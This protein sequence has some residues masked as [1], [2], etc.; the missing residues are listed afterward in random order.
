MLTPLHPSLPSASLPSLEHFS[1]KDFEFVYEPSDD[2]YLFIDSLTAERDFIASKHP[3]VCV[4]L[5]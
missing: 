2:T 1:F 4:E 3:K 5:G